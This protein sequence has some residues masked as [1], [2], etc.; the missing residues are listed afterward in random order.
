[1]RAS[2]AIRGILGRSGRA[3]TLPE[4]RRTDYPAAAC[5]AATPTWAAPQYAGSAACRTC[6]PAIA[7]DFYRNPHH[8]TI[9]LGTEPP[10]R[11]GC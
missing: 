9:A 5:L 7:A 3:F 1:M 8:K 6:H 11:T 4:R 10:E 2:T